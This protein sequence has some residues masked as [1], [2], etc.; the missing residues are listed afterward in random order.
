MYSWSRYFP[1]DLFGVRNYEA[2]YR[3]AEESLRPLVAQHRT[4]LDPSNPRDYVDAFL[5]EMN[6]R[7]NNAKDSFFYGVQ[8][9]ELKCNQ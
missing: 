2:S 7:A 4:T 5:V 8:L 6:A 1:F 3:R 9:T